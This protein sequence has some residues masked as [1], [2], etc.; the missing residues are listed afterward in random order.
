M[1]AQPHL[2]STP[3]EPQEATVIVTRPKNGKGTSLARHLRAD[4]FKVLEAKDA[5]EMMAWCK[6]FKSAESR[7]PDVMVSDEQLP[8]M[9]CLEAVEA[10]RRDGGAP[11]FILVT[12]RGDWPTFVAAERMGAAYVF[13]TSNDDSA[14]RS[15]VFSL[16]RAW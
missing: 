1:N 6:A 5:H 15:A 13:E 8:D 3:L 12:R 4:G 2:E 11:P 10:M 9:T 7:L 16:T 14:L